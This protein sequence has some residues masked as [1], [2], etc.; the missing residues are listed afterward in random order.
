MS[1]QLKSVPFRSLWHSLATKSEIEQ[2]YL[3]LSTPHYQLPSALDLVEP[4]VL[5]I[6]VSHMKEEFF[7]AYLPERQAKDG[8]REP[9]FPFQFGQKEKHLG[10]KTKGVRLPVIPSIYAI[11]KP[12][13]SRLEISSLNLSKHPFITSRQL[14]FSLMQFRPASKIGP[15]SIDK[16]IS[17]EEKG[18]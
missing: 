18:S 3:T 15:D 13:R 10:I 7:P 8:L 2:I 1:D 12:R 11:C 5:W 17:K 14:P 16:P 9:Y 6:L 4:K